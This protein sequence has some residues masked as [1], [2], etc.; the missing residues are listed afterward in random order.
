MK[1]S[2]LLLIILSIFILCTCNDDNDSDNDSQPTLGEIGN[3]WNVKVNGVNTITVEIIEKVGDIYTLE[4]SYAKLVSK[5][6]KFGFN[7]SE[8]IDYVYS[9]GDDGKPFT[10]VEFDAEV[11]DVYTAEID[12][13]Y[14]TREVIEKETYE[15]PALEKELE[16]IGVHEVIP[17][18]IPSNF[19]GFTIRVI[20][21]YW[22]PDYGLVC[23]DVYTEEGDHITIEFVSI[24]L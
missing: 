20:I 16:T 23:A 17:Y 22:H 8:V 12:G 4:V 9:K 15:I 11:G 6:I 24:D 18:G 21:W 19:F 13:I 5:E 10:M 2:Y 1:H 7:G 14:H 3:K